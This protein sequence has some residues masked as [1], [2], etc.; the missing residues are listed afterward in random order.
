[1]KKL[2]KIFRIKKETAT[3]TPVME[4]AMLPKLEKRSK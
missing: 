2:K 1:M 3:A 4:K